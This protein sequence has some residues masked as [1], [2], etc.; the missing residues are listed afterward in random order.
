[1]RGMLGAMRRVVIFGLASSCLLVVTGPARAVFV[2]N[3]LWEECAVSREDAHDMKS[4]TQVL[5]C[6]QYILGVTDAQGE[7]FDGNERSATRPQAHAN[8]PVLFCRSNDTSS[9]QVMSL[10]E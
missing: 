1:M 4:T 9:G 10:T 6:A 5:A 2:G 7:L 8:M 3:M